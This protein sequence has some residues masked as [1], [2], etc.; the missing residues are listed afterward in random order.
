MHSAGEVVLLDKLDRCIEQGVVKKLC[1]TYLIGEYS[2]TLADN[3]QLHLTSCL[4]GLVLPK[5]VNLLLILHE[6]SS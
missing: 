6:N 5:Q 4:T 1:C 2:H 3:T